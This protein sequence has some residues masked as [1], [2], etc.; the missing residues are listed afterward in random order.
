[1]IFYFIFLIV[2]T[3]FILFSKANHDE[4]ELYALNVLFNSTNGNFWTQSDGWNNKFDE[5]Y[6]SWYGILCNHENNVII[7]DLSSNNLSGTI[8]KEIGNF[9]ALKTMYVSG[10]NLFG[11]LPKEIGN[12][13]KLENLYMDQ[14]FLSNTIPIEI[15]K[16]MYLES[17]I[18][19]ENK[20]SGPIPPFIG[21]LTKLNELILR[22]NLL[23]N[24]IPSSIGHISTLQSLDLQSNLLTST[25]PSSLGNLTKL[26]YLNLHVNKLTGQIPDEICYLSKLRTFNFYHNHLSKTIPNEITNLKNLDQLHGHGNYFTGSLPSQIGDLS[27]LNSLNFGNNNLNHTI[28]SSITQ[29]KFLK[30]LDLQSNH[31]SGLLP[32]QTNHLINLENL[33]LNSNKFSGTFPSLLGMSN[34]KIVDGSNNFFSGNLSAFLDCISLEILSINDNFFSGSL[35]NIFHSKNLVNLFLQKNHFFGVLPNSFFQSLPFLKRLYVS[36]NSFFGTIPISILNHTNLE[37]LYLNENQFQIPFPNITG[38]LN[39]KEINIAKNLFYGKLINLEQNYKLTSLFLHD[40]DLNGKFF[41]AKNFLDVTL[42]NNNFYGTINLENPY[43]NFMIHNNKFSGHI[44]EIH[45]LKEK[46]KFDNIY[47]MVSFKWYSRIDC[48]GNF[49]PWI[50]LTTIF[51]EIVYVHEKMSSCYCFWSKLNSKEEWKCLFSSTSDELDGVS[52]QNSHNEIINWYGPQLCNQYIV[53]Q[54]NI[55]QNLLK[56]D[57]LY[58][59]TTNNYKNGIWNYVFLSNTKKNKIINLS[60]IYEGTIFNCTSTLWKPK[61]TKHISILGNKFQFDEHYENIASEELSLTLTIPGWI[62]WRSTIISSSISFVFILF[63]IWWYSI[64][65]ETNFFKMNESFFH[66]KILFFGFQNYPEIYIKYVIDFFFLSILFSVYI[67]SPNYYIHGYFLDNIS[68]TNMNENIYGEYILIFLFPLFNFFNYRLIQICSELYPIPEPELQKNEQTKWNLI[69]IIP[70]IVTYIVSIFC[71]FIY[72]LFKFIPKNNYF[73][74]TLPSEIRETYDILYPGL[75]TI[76]SRYI[77]PF[78]LKKINLNSRQNSLCK[79]FNT[80]CFVF[81]FPILFVFLFSGDCFNL[82]V[83][84]WD[85]CYL[86]TNNFD[87]IQ[88][89]YP[90]SIILSHHDIC[91]MRQFYEIKWNRCS[92][93]VLATIT[94]LNVKKLTYLIFIFPLVNLGTNFVKIFFPSCGK[95]FSF[96]K[97]KDRNEDELNKIL[98]YVY[99]IILYGS[100]CPLMICMIYFAIAVNLWTMFMNKFLFNVKYIANDDFVKI[101]NTFMY[102]CLALNNIFLIFFWFSNDFTDFVFD[103][104]PITLIGFQCIIWIRILWKNKYCCFVTNENNQFK[105]PLNTSYR[106]IDRN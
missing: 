81:L 106:L 91:G 67:C 21:N 95:Y 10:N 17:L 80:L 14:N 102:I 25:I 96:M 88:S 72:I 52:Q 50:N 69:Y 79:I 34:L 24:V 92:R 57:I 65:F 49:Y 86:N 48:E 1:M 78:F 2:C 75:L 83:T 6:C 99:Y 16:L 42:M 103:R 90:Y 60:S 58:F 22:N 87:M 8:P 5:N 30:L 63:C 89:K 55:T 68:L 71:L 4:S 104:F 70:Y 19:R 37:E 97:F 28:P 98:T 64:K 3:Q 59:L 56:N 47:P 105:I 44:K 12:L 29:L 93:S 73:A 36:C 46:E 76:F 41:Q 7:F 18:L 9:K 11:A 62:T 32:N 77:L 45:F 40:N 31:F 51:N 20:F 100:F 101:S 15:S 23:T 94:Q 27:D 66:N 54:E 53:L 84:F 33:I 61:I 38:I 39:L 26:L 82:W 74:T 35:P 13:L 85:S 43:R